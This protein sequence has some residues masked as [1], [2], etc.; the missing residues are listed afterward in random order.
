MSQQDLLDRLETDL[1][2]QLEET[3]VQF[4]HLD[5]LTLQRRRNPE[6]WNILECFAHLNRYA[7]DYIPGLERAI[8]KAKARRWGPGYDVRYSGRGRRAVRR[9][10]IGNAKTYKASKYYN[11]YQRAAGQEAVKTFIINVERLLRVIQA[12]R[13]IDINRATV[14]KVHAWVGRYSVANLLEYL[15]LH[16]QRHLLQAKRLLQV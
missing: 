4:A 1:R 2:A 8:H 9:A 12:A 7:E 6:G 14:P 13:S 10:A 16:G 3:R 5:L 11:F 15:T